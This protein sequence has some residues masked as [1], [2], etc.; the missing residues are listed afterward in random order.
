MNYLRVPSEI[1]LADLQSRET[2]FSPGMY[3]RVVVPARTT[4]PIRDL[5]NSK[6]PFDQGSE[7]GSMWYMRR[8]THA[9]IRTKALQAYSYLIYPK[10]DAIVPINPRVFDHPNLCDGDILMSKDSNVGE[11]AIVDGNGWKSHM[12]SGG[13]VRLHPVI[14][15]WYFYS[16]LK[17]PIF[18]AQLHALAPRGA[19]IRHA[20]KL[21]LDCLIP[22]PEQKEAGAVI[23]YV[24][25][26]MKA[27]VDKAKA[28]RQKNE[29]IDASIASELK[30][31][32][33]R[34]QKFV[35]QLPTSGELRA[36]TRLD[37][38]LYSEDLK[39]KLFFLQNYQFG[40]GTYRE[41]DFEISRGQNLQVS[42]IGHSVYSDEAKT[43][44][45]RLVA[46]TDISE[47]GVSTSFR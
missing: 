34:T 40:T 8:S 13:V 7:P 35:Y 46:P 9:L 23:R 38:G 14:D 36:F 3:R 41:L 28:I 39:E 24:S 19:T 33:D 32:Q 4:R 42:C 43:N 17:H 15:R 11:C 44:F 30:I 26:L 47:C 31:R 18:K 5:L 2:S 12:F 21:W 29:L 45:Y 20:K 37:T 10:G 1:T 6:E 25:V 27:I 16:F 22:F